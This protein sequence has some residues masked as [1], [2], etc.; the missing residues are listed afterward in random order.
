M[1]NNKDYL[2]GALIGAMW[3]VVIMWGFGTLW[4]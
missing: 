1:G 3:I 4:P 2:W